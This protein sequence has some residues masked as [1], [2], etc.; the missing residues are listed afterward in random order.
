MR[1]TDRKVERRP[2]TNWTGLSLREFGLKVS[3]ANVAQLGL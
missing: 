1:P 2:G 3:L